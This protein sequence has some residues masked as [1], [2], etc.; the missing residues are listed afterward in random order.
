MIPEE[1]NN[2][3]LYGEVSEELRKFAF[4]YYPES[5]KS[6]VYYTQIWDELGFDKDTFDRLWYQIIK[7]LQELQNTFI[8][9]N[10]EPWTN[11]TMRLDHSGKFNIEFHYDDFTEIDAYA[12]LMLWKHMIAKVHLQDSFE[13]SSAN[14]YITYLLN[15]N[16][17][18]NNLPV[19]L[20]QSK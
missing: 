20:I 10:Q 17:K 9:H 2:I 1:W 3:I 12:R 16:L 14:D 8:T 4:Y 11:L 7:Y 15:N 13:I 5:R 19:E 18:Y 6:P